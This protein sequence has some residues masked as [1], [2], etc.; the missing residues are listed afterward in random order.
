MP[1]HFLRPCRPHSDDTKWRALHEAGQ[2]GE[3]GEKEYLLLRFP[4]ELCTDG[5]HAINN[6]PN[7]DWPNTLQG[8]AVEHYAGWHG[9]LRPREFHLAARVLDR[10]TRTP[11]VAS[12]ELI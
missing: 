6:P 11:T 9:Q 10:T 4:S 3:H 8:D 2:V 7:P 1:Q 5:A 12:T